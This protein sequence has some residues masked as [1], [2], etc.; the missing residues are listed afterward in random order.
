MDLRIPP[1]GRGGV[2]QAIGVQQ[3]QLG[4]QGKKKGLWGIW[5]TC[6]EFKLDVAEATR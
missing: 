6:A 1:W 5:S 4:S 2:T 3:A